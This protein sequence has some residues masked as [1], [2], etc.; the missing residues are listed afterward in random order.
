MQIILNLSLISFTLFISVLALP[1]GNEPRRD[2]HGSNRDFQNSHGKQSSGMDQ[3]HSIEEAGAN[4]PRDAP[5]PPPPQP[6][7]RP[8]SSDL[9]F[10]LRC[11]PE[12]AFRLIPY[13]LIDDQQS[14][15]SC[16][17]KSVQEVPAKTSSNAGAPP[18]PPPGYQWGSPQK[19]GRFPSSKER[20]LHST[21]NQCIQWK[22][23]KQPN[24]SNQKE[25]LL[26]AFWAWLGLGN[27]TST[28][29]TTTET[30]T[31]SSS[32]TVSNGGSSAISYDL[33]MM[34]DMTLTTS[35]PLKTQITEKLT[36]FTNKKDLET[37]WRSL[38]KT[39]T[40]ANS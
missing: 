39:T 25:K 4:P 27:C 35:C 32:T 33:P 9:D 6:K 29:T 37:Y 21:W 19:P 36:G 31:D 3:R 26:E 18:P 20:E 2:S 8:T 10:D 24:S 15:S 17:N 14:D 12:E 38:F 7:P 34:D 22:R 40:N 13:V 23:G 30:E 5:P 1:P 16:K 11:P 28:T